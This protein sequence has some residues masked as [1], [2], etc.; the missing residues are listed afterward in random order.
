MAIDSRHPASRLD[1]APGTVLLEGCRPHTGGCY[2]AEAL[3]L[4]GQYEAVITLVEQVRPRLRPTYRVHAVAQLAKARLAGD[5]A[6]AAQVAA[7]LS[8]MIAK[9]KTQVRETAPGLTLWDW[10][11][12]ASQA[13]NI[14]R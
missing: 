8:A 9:E 11:E 13:A 1:V 10:Y 12:L 4:L 6:S 3:F 2:L 14:T 5:T 7:Q